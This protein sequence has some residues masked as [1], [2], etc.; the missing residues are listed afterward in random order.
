MALIFKKPTTPTRRHTALVVDRAISKSRPL[1]KSLMKSLPYKAGRNTS[2]KLT[3]RHRGGRGKRQYRDID[4]LRENH[5]VSGVVVSIEYDPNRSANIALVNYKD[6]DKRYI[7]SPDG[8]KI[9]DEVISGDKA[10]IRIGNALPLKN[11]PSAQFVHNIE[12]I[13]G[14]GGILVRTAGSAAQIQGGAKGYIQLKMPSG[15]IRLI[16]ELCYAT[17]GVIGNLD[18]KNEKLGKAGRKRHMGF[19]PTVR[20]TAQSGGKHPHGDGQGKSGRHGP[21]GP[22]KDPWG[23]RTGTRTRNNKLTDKYIIKR[24]GT[25][26]GNKF[27]TYKTII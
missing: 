25:V 6:G 19:K 20:G 8:L 27:K 24:R 9:G 17:I 7:L 15:E 21:G 4:F 11:I 18:H 1:L 26:R 16:K 12:L 13:A 3:V 10:P 5:N 14:K 2:G 22:S 23:N